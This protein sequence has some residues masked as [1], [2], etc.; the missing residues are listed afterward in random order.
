MVKLGLKPLKRNKRKY[1]SY[2]GTVGK[3]VDNHINREFYADNPNEIKY[4]QVTR[5]LVNEDV[6]TR[7]LRSL[8]NIE[9]NY[10]KIILTME[11]S[12][13]N[14]Y[15]GIKIINIIDFLLENDK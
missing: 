14:D 15:N 8:E 3:V 2:K 1:S 7:E 13:N 5:L 6:K 12:I 10:E 11:K 9:D 4:Y